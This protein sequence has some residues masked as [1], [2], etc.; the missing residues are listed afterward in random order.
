MAVGLS[1]GRPVLSQTHTHTGEKRHTWGACSH[2]LYSHTHMYAHTTTDTRV[3]AWGGLQFKLPSCHQAL[4]DGSLSHGF[5]MIGSYWLCNF[6][7]GI[8]GKA[9]LVTE[10]QFHIQIDYSCCTFAVMCHFQYI[11]VAYACIGEESG[12]VPDCKDP[13]VTC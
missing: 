13:Y 1:G 9:D 2:I 4:I 10:A 3:W 11:H 12:S 5:H 6:S 8:T 7:M